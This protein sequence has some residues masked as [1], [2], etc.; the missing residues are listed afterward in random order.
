MK[1]VATK[2]YQNRCRDCDYTWYPREKDEVCPKCKNSNV[3]YSRGLG[4]WVLL[5]FVLLILAA[6]IY[7]VLSGRFNLG[8]DPE[9]V[10]AEKAEE[11]PI[12][13]ASDGQIEGLEEA[14]ERQPEK[15]QDVTTP[16]PV[17][18]LT[19]PR[20]WTSKNG[21]TLQASLLRLNLVEGQYVGVFEKPGGE[22]FEYKIGNL[23]K[24]DVDLVKG[25]VG[26]K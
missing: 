13:P 21:R 10:K 14:P 24:A 15:S 1:R 26:K 22:I 16:K 12:T 11:S 20:T 7:A 17:E 8:G 4:R 25:I 19:Q 9:S 3:T 6:G 5:L 18:S 2:R 23:S